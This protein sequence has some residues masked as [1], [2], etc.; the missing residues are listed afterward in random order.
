MSAIP[1]TTGTATTLPE[2][3][4]QGLREQIFANVMTLYPQLVRSSYQYNCT[5]VANAR[6]IFEIIV[7]ASAYDNPTYTYTAVLISGN[8]LGRTMAAKG[9][10]SPS[11]TSA[12]EGL[13]RTTCEALGWFTETLLGEMQHPEAS[14]SG[15]VNFQM[16][17]Q[18]FHFAHVQRHMKP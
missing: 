18:G 4:L 16:I 10:A 13:L 17:E 12:L 3:N 14:D 15:I 7:T 9:P 5:G 8:A 1:V 11:V 6:E 2:A